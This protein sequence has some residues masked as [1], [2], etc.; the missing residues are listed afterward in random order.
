VNAAFKKPTVNVVYNVVNQCHAVRCMTVW[1]ME[2]SV[3]A[4][5]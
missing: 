1:L 4:I 5:V 3:I 2:N